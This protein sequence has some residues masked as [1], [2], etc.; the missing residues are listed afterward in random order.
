MKVRCPV[1][2]DDSVRN[3]VR[4]VFAHCLEFFSKLYTQSMGR[5][6]LLLRIVR[7]SSQNCIHC[8]DG[9]FVCS[10]LSRI[11]LKTVYTARVRMAFVCAI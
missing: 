5:A 4:L 10:A 1:V 2:H 8:P 6:G 11:L 3:D 7:N 9:D